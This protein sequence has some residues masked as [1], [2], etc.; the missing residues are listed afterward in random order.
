MRHFF[1][2]RYRWAP[3]NDKEWPFFGYLARRNKETNVLEVP[4]LIEEKNGEI[5]DP[6]NMRRY[7]AITELT[8][9]GS[10]SIPEIK[11]KLNDQSEIKV[12]TYTMDIYKVRK[13]HLLEGA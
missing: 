12:S 7:V 5:N 13:K 11:A 6:M 8:Q 3:S 2:F 1:I 10:Q 4:Y 9:I